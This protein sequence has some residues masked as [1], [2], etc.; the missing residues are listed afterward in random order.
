MLLCSTGGGTAP[1]ADETAAAGTADE[2]AGDRMGG[3]PTMTARPCNL[4]RL[5]CNNV[6]DLG[7]VHVYT[8]PIG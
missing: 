1:E 7:D 2:A 5:L 3:L 6:L 8:R 4:S